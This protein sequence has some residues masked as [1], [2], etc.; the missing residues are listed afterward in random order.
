M[1]PRGAFFI[2]LGVTVRFLDCI[3]CGCGSHKPISKPNTAACLPCGLAD[4]LRR[5][6]RPKGSMPPCRRHRGEAQK[7]KPRPRRNPERT[8]CRAIIGLRRFTKRP[9]EALPWADMSG[10][11]CPG[12]ILNIS[13]LFP[14]DIVSVQQLMSSMTSRLLKILVVHLLD[15]GIL[16]ALAYGLGLIFT[17]KAL[18]THGFGV[19]IAES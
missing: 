16:M 5:G 4:G 17:V 7:R 6:P 1:R 19:D 10:I 12:Y 13:V 14:G 2:P 18:R 8:S 9:T 3:F 11:I 15:G